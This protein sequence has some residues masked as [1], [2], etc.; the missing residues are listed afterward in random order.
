LVLAILLVGYAALFVRLPSIGRSAA[1]FDPLEPRGREAETA[2]E[3][4]RFKD[5]L[6][7]VRELAN[8]HDAD[9]VIAYWLAEIHRGLGE[10]NDEARAW[11]R[12]LDLTGSA[13]FACPAL[14]EAYTHAGDH[15][16]ALGAYERCASAGG[17]DA[18]RWLDLGAA[19]AAAHRDR[20]ATIAYE[21]SR[22]LDDSNPRL[23]GPVDDSTWAG[24]SR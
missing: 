7:I 13:D 24:S 5:A 3:E 11:E 2:I 19:Y 1:P 16:K 23:P 12:V 8:E 21:K 22:A 9:P 6:P 10:A 18:E 4:G 20:E 17:D 14:P 15:D